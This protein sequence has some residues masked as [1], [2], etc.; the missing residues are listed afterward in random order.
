MRHQ[1]YD[2]Q[3]KERIQKQASGPSEI[4][5]S[6]D[7]Q[8]LLATSSFEA[9]DA[10]YEKSE[11][12]MIIH[13]LGG[14]GQFLRQ[15]EWGTL[16]GYLHPK[17]TAF[18][19][20][21]TNAIGYTPQ[22]DL[23]G[24]SISQ[25]FIQKILSQDHQLFA[26]EAAASR[27]HTSPLLDAVLIA[28]WRDAQTHGL[29]SAFF[30]HGLDLVIKNL[31]ESDQQAF[32]DIGSHILSVGELNKIKALIDSQLDQDLT[33]ALLSDEISWDK[34]QFTKAFKNTTGYA[35]F[36]YLTWQRMRKA[37]KLLATEL[38]I[39]SISLEVGYAN[40]AKFSAAFRRLCGCSPSQWRQ[41]LKQ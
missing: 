30:D 2:A 33:V 8:V 35:P 4:M 18:A 1:N 19:L 38:P 17:T 28:M 7:G 41:T 3:F 14:G 13:V 26:L 29:S 23:L 27:L 15:G 16:S 31:I 25:D 32:S 24:I 10:I 22:V 12:L 21:E 5:T 37:K 36:Q 11:H 20:P 9:A 34:R 6:L 39:I 40:P